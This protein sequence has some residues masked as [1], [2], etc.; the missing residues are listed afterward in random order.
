MLGG[1]RVDL[2]GLRLLAAVAFAA[3][4]LIGGGGCTG[5]VA[6]PRPKP[7]LESALREI[8][9][10][11]SSREGKLY[12]AECG[13]SV[14]AWLAPVLEHCLASRSPGDP[15]A[16]EVLVRVAADGNAE[17]VLFRNRAGITACLQPAF[18][19]ATYPSPPRSPW[20]VRT[21]VSI[22]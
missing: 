14:V 15:D 12:D 9:A 16:F 17:K 4:A 2:S 18:E 10:N 8:E 21:Q 3:S 20:W 22:Q 13:R 5:V 6:P 11:E 19:N 7:E 1:A